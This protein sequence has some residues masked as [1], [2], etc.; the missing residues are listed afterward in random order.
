MIPQQ[1]ADESH[2]A[3]LQAKATLEQLIA[4]QDYKRV[5][6]PFDGMVTARYVDPGQLI[7]QATSSTS[8]ADAIWPSRG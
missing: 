6:A 1:T 8:L 2:A 7:P 4:L 3:M 5:T